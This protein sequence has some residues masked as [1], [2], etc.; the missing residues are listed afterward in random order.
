M[1]SETPGA[2]IGRIVARGVDKHLDEEIEAYCLRHPI[3]PNDLQVLI[4]P[5]TPERLSITLCPYDERLIL[6]KRLF[7][8]DIILRT[9]S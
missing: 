5:L 2:T 3:T 4:E 1:N 9:L 8:M 6:P 7:H